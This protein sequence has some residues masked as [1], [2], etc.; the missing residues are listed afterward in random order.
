MWGYIV[1]QEY[2]IN[3]TFMIISPI[4]KIYIFPNSIKLHHRFIM[5]LSHSPENDLQR[6]IIMLSMCLSIRV[7]F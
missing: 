7:V 2:E 1:K 6:T 5:N 3:Q 4:C